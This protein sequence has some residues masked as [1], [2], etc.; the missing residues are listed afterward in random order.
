VGFLAAGSVAGCTDRH[1]VKAAS[2]LFEAVYVCIISAPLGGSQAA[3][4]PAHAGLASFFLS[5]M[6]CLFFS[7]T[8]YWLVR[9]LTVV[10]PCSLVCVAADDTCRDRH[11]RPAVFKYRTSH[12]AQGGWWQLLVE[13]CLLP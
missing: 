7:V 11:G 6:D 5:H 13:I 2:G 12:R 8:H 10:L 3:S 1:Q 4:Q 9:K